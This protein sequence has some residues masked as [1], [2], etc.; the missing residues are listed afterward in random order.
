[1][2]R[3]DRKQ[4]R[5]SRAASPEQ[6]GN[7]RDLIVG[8]VALGVVIAVFAVFAL[9]AVTTE[10][11]KPDVVTGTFFVPYYNEDR[12][13]GAVG[14]NTVDGGPAGR[15]GQVPVVVGQEVNNQ[16]W[17]EVYNT[18]AGA[19][20]VDRKTANT[21]LVLPS[22]TT[23]GREPVRLATPTNP[24]IIANAAVLG[25][26][27]GEN[28]FVVRRT[29][30]GGDVHL[31]SATSVAGGVEVG[32]RELD[33]TLPTET[34]VVDEAVVSGNERFAGLGEAGRYTE[35]LAAATAD[36]DLF[37]VLQGPGGNRI[38]RVSAPTPEAVADYERAQQAATPGTKVAPPLLTFE[39][40]GAIGGKAVLVTLPDDSGVAAADPDSGEI[41]FWDAGGRTGGVAVDGL[42]GATTVYPVRGGSLAWF[43][44]DDGTRQWRAVGAGPS[45]QVRTVTVSGAAG[46]S[47]AP[48]VLV[49]SSL[50]TAS[51]ANG[52]ILATNVDTGVAISVWED[53]RYPLD[54]D[55]EPGG[56]NLFPA[57]YAAVEVQR[58][59]S[60]VSV[61]VPAA[62]RA[63]LLAADGSLV[64]QLEKGRARPFDP[65]TLIDPN[66]RG[67]AEEE[68]EEPDDIEQ[69]VGN[70]PA[71]LEREGDSSLKCEDATDQEPR[72]PLLLP[73]SGAL[74][75]RSITV[76]WR[77]DLDSASECLPGFRVQIRKVP[78]GD[79]Q[80]RQLERPN[81]TTATLRDL[82]PESQYEI[83]VLAFIGDKVARSNTALYR[84]GPIGPETPEN[85]RFTE[86][87]SQWEIVWEACTTQGACEVP[88]V[89]FDVDWYD[90]AGG[91][92]GSGQALVSAAGPK[93]YAVGIDRQVNVGRNLC[94]TV[95]AIAGNLASEPSLPV[96]AVRE[97]APLGSR[98]A[99]TVEA[100]RQGTTQFYEIVF[101]LTDFGRR[102]FPSI[103]GTRGD[104]NVTVTFTGIPTYQG[105]NRYVWTFGRDV[106]PVPFTAIP[107]GLGGFGY[108]VTFSNT[109]GSE[110]HEGSGSFEPLS[111]GTLEI[112]VTGYRFNNSARNWPVNF[113]P[114]N[115]CP[116]GVQTP[117]LVVTPPP[118]CAPYPNP[119]SITC[120][121]FR[122][123]GV[124]NV[125]RTAF[126]YQVFV[127]NPSGF[128][129]DGI[130]FIAGEGEPFTLDQPSGPSFTSR[131]FIAKTERETPDGVD[132]LVTIR[133]TNTT[134][135]PNIRGCALVGFPSADTTVFRC[136][137]V[138]DNQP[139][140]PTEFQLEPGPSLPRGP[141]DRLRGTCEFASGAV[142]ASGTTLRTYCIMG[143]RKLIDLDD[144]N[145]TTTTNTEDPTCN[146]LTDPRTPPCPEEDPE[147]SSVP[148]GLVGGTG[149]LLYS[150]QSDRRRRRSF[151]ASQARHLHEKKAGTP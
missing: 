79:L 55:L 32:A 58:H 22:L 103:M 114:R 30:A 119:L 108:E 37:F 46:L 125:S 10:S 57:D 150:F 4:L 90:Q 126:G 13:N 3:G 145:N 68:P 100:R 136:R 65:N 64:Q 9:V 148:I 35:S 107:A 7:R 16:Q 56:A 6:G 143:L 123:T 11:E 34:L 80:D 109:R 23:A 78:G 54:P 121:T 133:N 19:F 77:Y 111:C 8:A 88:A 21:A 72:S 29:A 128:T 97:L 14:F 69:T 76:R 138:Y 42:R 98:D 92:V 1:V 24:A 62:A 38:I 50:F 124:D 20:L 12:T 91:Q 144:P 40:L 101:S 52:R 53:G 87:Q 149:L 116:G 41:S 117:A 26:A 83:T 115:P 67:D 39:D 82:Q 36:G 134:A 33:G 27:T 110:S 43:A 60:R 147:E 44:V 113:T 141:Y 49:G 146:P 66:R 140:I 99:F 73:Q 61:N 104:V 122:Q 112:V 130:R 81:S 120:D 105:A 71:N 135:R 89:Q 151:E 137:S 96:C 25:Y 59:G 45:G 132:Y 28:L 5:R 63:V 102:N 95:T 47:I 31:L 127:E 48:P 131:L 139:L 118:G 74:A 15:M 51:R 85:V 86:D 18:D 84:T 129:F 17:V 75:A 93:T 142:L 2:S 106:E 94:F 70:I